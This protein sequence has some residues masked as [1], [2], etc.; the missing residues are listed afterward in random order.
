MTVTGCSIESIQEQMTSDLD[1]IFQ[2]LSVNKLMLNVIKTDF[3]LIGSRQKSTALEDSV[4]LSANNVTLSK[5]DLVKCLGVDKVVSRKRPLCKNLD[6]SQ[7]VSII[8][9]QSGGWDA[10]YKLGRQ[11]KKFLLSLIWLGSDCRKHSKQLGWSGN[12]KHGRLISPVNLLILEAPDETNCNKI[13]LTA[14][15]LKMV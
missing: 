12:W 10:D 11:L 15:S 5:V 9:S 6:Q 2:W 14:M 4:V 13:F 7:G 3:M 1:N 8:E